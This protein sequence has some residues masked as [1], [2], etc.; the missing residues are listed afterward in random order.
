MPATTDDGF[1]T[2]EAPKDRWGRYVIEHDGTKKSFSRVTTIAKSLDDEG[3]LTAWKGRMTATGLVQRPDLLAA[4]STVLEDRGALDRIVQQSIE[5]A[6]ASSKANIGTA[7]HQVTQQLDLGRKPAILPGLQAD[8][9]S[10]IAG[11]NAHGIIFDENLIEVLLVNE[12]Y[13]YAGTADRIAR[14]RSRRRKQVFDLKTG[15]IEYAINSIAVQMAM[16]AN[17]EYIYDWRTKTQ[18]P[19]PE[20]DKSRGIII[21]LPAG[22]AKLDLYEIDLEAGWEA[23]KLAIQVRDWRKRKDL[24]IKV[25]VGAAANEEDPPTTEVAAPTPSDDIVKRYALDRIRNLPKEAQEQLKKLW[26]APDTKLH[27]MTEAQLTELDKLLI[28][29]EANYAAGFLPK[30]DVEPLPRK[31]T[32]KK[33]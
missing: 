8:V 20:M 9:D 13:G 6:G 24:H 19:M 26:P 23:A 33:K 17:A 1:T 10:Y 4:A 18:L 12:K 32:A 3:A 29:L 16:Y 2:A 14:L 28:E 11:I 21:H 30:P 22:Q 15:N 27:D 7:L 31:K 5:A 25:H